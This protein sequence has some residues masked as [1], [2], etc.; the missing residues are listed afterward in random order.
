LITPA[1]TLALLLALALSASCSGIRGWQQRQTQKQRET[2]LADVAKGWCQTIRASQVIPV[3]PLT[4]DLQPGDVFLVS[5]TMESQS[6]EYKRKGFLPLDYHLT[7]LQPKGYDA[8]Y[9]HSILQGGAPS[10]VLVPGAWMRPNGAPPAA[11][12]TWNMAARA[13]FPSYSFSVQSGGGFSLALPVQGVPVG[14]SLLGTQAASGTIAISD[15]KTLGVDM[16]SLW[17]ELQT[18]A[19]DNRALLAPY[20]STP[21][22]AGYVRMVTRVYLTGGVAVSVSSGSSFGAGADAGVPRPIDL[23]EP[24][25]GGAAETSAQQYTDS[26]RLL[27]ESLA[28]TGGGPGGSLRITA[29]GGNTVSLKETFDPPLVIGYLGFDCRI[30][31]GGALGNPVPTRIALEDPGRAHAIQARDRIAAVH[32]AASVDAEI[33][34]MRD[35][36]A[37][38]LANG[39]LRRSAIAILESFDELERFVRD[40]MP[41]YY[42]VPQAGVFVLRRDIFGESEGSEGD[43]GYARFLRFK[44]SLAL[45]KNAIDAALEQ[46]TFEVVEADLMRLTVSPGDGG[47][48]LDRIERDRAEIAGLLE[49]EPWK[50]AQ[51]EVEYALQQWRRHRESI[52][53]TP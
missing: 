21:D 49:A 28:Q 23:L 41:T 12:E 10:P 22:R 9:S 52:P 20:A 13:A 47:P 14:L 19:Y 29:A 31:A 17:Q 27:N 39:A 37:D 36:A 7:R 2:E 5:E 48:E 38:E 53:Q 42:R 30:L 34:L 16:L 35:Y 33:G 26:L 6:E 32:R 1:R 40:E 25:E 45:S 18:W 44:N 50:G 24:R 43:T 46:D 8:F 51:Q 3:Y 4:E 15:A 11:N